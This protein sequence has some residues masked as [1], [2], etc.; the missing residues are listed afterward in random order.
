MSEEVIYAE[1]KESAY[2][3]INWDFDVVREHP[4][5]DLF[6]DD[7]DAPELVFHWR[8]EDYQG[9][10]FVVYEYTFKNVLYY[11]YISSGYG[12]CSGCDSWLAAI[13]E[14]YC[15]NKQE[16]HDYIETEYNNLYVVDDKND[17]KLS[18][19]SHSTLVQNLKGWVA[20]ELD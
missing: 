17:I 11:L 4:C 13:D 10:I 7:K 19:Y 1:V 20:D 14:G 9:S 18:P 6:N 2:E 5:E 8:E 16:M 3:Y 15:E 12:S